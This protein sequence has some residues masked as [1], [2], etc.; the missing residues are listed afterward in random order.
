MDQEL[1]TAVFQRWNHGL[2][3]SEEVFYKAASALGLDP[4]DALLEARWYTLV[5][6]DLSKMASGGEL[7]SASIRL[8]AAAAGQS[9]DVLTK[10]AHQY[11]LSP[12]ELVVAELRERNWVPDLGL[13][14][15]ALMAPTMADG[16]AG[17]QGAPMM[18]PAALGGSAAQPATPPPA[19]PI[20]GAMVQQQPEARYKPSPMAPIQTPPSAE[21]N[22]MGLVDA[23]RHPNPSQEMAMGGMGQAGM[24]PEAAPGSMGPEAAP[25]GMAGQEAPP[26]MAPEEKLQQVDP[27]ID[28]ETMQRWAPKL[29]EIEQQTGIQMN[30]PTQIQKFI[31][32]MQKADQ[33]T[34]DDA[35]KSV[36]QPQPLNK[37]TGGVQAQK[38][39][40]QDPSGATQP[41]ST[42]DL[43]KAAAFLGKATRMGMGAMRK[44]GIPGPPPPSLQDKLKTIGGAAGAG[45]AAGYGAG[46]A[47]SEK[48]AAR[49]P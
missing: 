36:N 6:H 15:T 22:L 19:E 46:R 14:K 23:A 12:Q 13:L 11:H 40:Q 27:S 20:P 2:P 21:G 48:K 24:P 16:S 28:P 39:E 29:Q 31:A 42:E 43:Q 8:Y 44:P 4:S 41:S 30:D 45:S 26:P 5:D 32:E 17:D 10:V 38:Q 7:S 18:D 47:G 34:L 3:V 9:S 37:P 35:I 1:A 25:A 49:L 33:K